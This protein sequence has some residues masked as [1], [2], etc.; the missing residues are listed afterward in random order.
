LSKHLSIYIVLPFPSNSRE[1]YTFNPRQR[2]VGLCEFEV[3]H[4]PQSKFQ[5]SQ[6]YTEKPCLGGWGGAGRISHKGT[7]FA[8]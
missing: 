6:S 3:Y 2:Q 5:D 8:T 4:G 7:S 1:A